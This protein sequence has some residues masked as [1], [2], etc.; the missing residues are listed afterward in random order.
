MLTGTAGVRECSMAA[1]GA[2]V[3]LRCAVF[4]LLALGSLALARPASAIEAVALRTDQDRIDI[5]TPAERFSGRGDRLQ[6]ETA[7]GPD[8]LAGRVEVKAATAG[9]NPNWMVFAL[10]NTTEKAVERWLVAE[11]FTFIGSGLTFPD[12]D[13]SRIVAVTPSQGFVPDRI[14][15]DRADIFQVSIEPGQ[16]VTFA[17]EMASDRFPHVTLWKPFVYEA[18]QRERT[19]LNGILLGISGLLALFLTAL[20]VANHKAVFPATGVLAWSVLAWL[21]VDFGFWHRIFRLTAEDNALYR[22]AA[23]AAVAASLVLFLY[24]FLKLARWHSWIRVFWLAWVLCQW[25][26]VGLAPIDPGLAA[27]LARFSFIVI[28]GLGSLFIVYLM[29]ANQDRAL[30]LLPSWLLLL[31]WV[32]AAALAA[33][34]RLSGEFIAVGLVSG[35]VLI[36]LL[37]G[38][39]VTQVAFRSLEGTP[40]GGAEHNQ[41]RSFA[42]EGAGLATFEWNSRRNDVQT[43]PI[44]EDVLGLQRGRLTCGLDDWL[45]HVGPRDQERLREQF[46]DIAVKGGGALHAEFMMRGSDNAPHWFALRGASL[47]QSDAR[48][49]RCVGIL[50]ETTREKQAQERILVDAI[51]DHRTGLPNREL[52][53]DRLGVAFR[54]ARASQGSLVVVL[55]EIAGLAALFDEFDETSVE[56]GLRSMLKRL[57]N[58]LSPLDTV[59]R[60][61][62]DRYAVLFADAGGASLTAKHI[63]LV[64]QSLRGPVP[65]GR[66]EQVFNVNLGIALLLDEHTEPSAVMR[67]AEAAL[68][69]AKRAGADR[70]EVFRPNMRLEADPAAEDI[71]ALRK[72]VERQQF[73]L[74]FQPVYG[75][76]PERLAGFEALARW[77]HPV[78]GPLGLNAFMPLA[79]SGGFAVPLA[80]HLL[81]MAG[82]AALGWQKAL[83]REQE[84]VFVNIDLGEG[85]P[86]RLDV[87]Q[88]VRKALTRAPL[89]RGLLRLCISDSAPGD[90]PELAMEILDR[91]RSVGAGICLTR[92]GAGEFP[93]SLLPRMALDAVKLD[94]GLCLEGFASDGGVALLRG[95]AALA[96][97]LGLAIHSDALESQ[98]D[99]PVLRGAGCTFGSGPL[100]GEP[101]DDRQVADLL[102]TVRSAERKSER[103]GSLTGGLL[104]KPATATAAAPANDPATSLK[105]TS[106]RKPSSQPVSQPATPR[107]ASAAPA[108]DYS[109]QAASAPESEAA[110][111]DQALS[112]TALASAYAAAENQVEYAMAANGGRGGVTPMG[113]FPQPSHVAATGG[114]NGL[115][116]GLGQGGP[117]PPPG[118]SDTPTKIIRGSG[119]IGAAAPGQSELAGG[120]A[121]LQRGQFGTKST[122]E[123][124]AAAT[125]AP[126]SLAVPVEPPPA[127]K[128]PPSPPFQAPPPA[129]QERPAGGVSVGF[130]DGLPDADILRGLAARLEAALKRD[131]Q[132]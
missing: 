82:R 45:R 73:A 25:G 128:P 81:E 34:G 118:R 55:F 5:T 130:A 12:L 46:K 85:L 22:A 102:A 115:A 96:R 29:L 120:L 112:A 80:M 36:L 35:L 66:T 18:K 57:Q 75:L 41:T 62:S 24:T 92:F 90:N 16:T 37:L 13:A 77:Q 105:R 119:V 129:S 84:P 100:Y 74:V 8:G 2:A 38:F 114:L 7:P 19:L 21:C 28:A 113:A 87:V 23:E 26:L 83:P 88:E 101:L 30:A 6:I 86:L 89:P 39:T 107:A 4:C 109:A 31:V 93:V 131:S 76:S 78:R 9:T 17:A 27:T 95:V 1:Q 3:A 43:G 122:M 106:T 52:F 53:A 123:G 56:G 99:L 117:V 125:L 98:E 69:R 103:R 126:P 94:R 97:E 110:R 51:R 59:G 116:D 72:A 60:M 104:T 58:A 14:A 108:A 48:T 111:Y 132:K 42:I 10:R 32:F 65:I 127:F 124:M 63:E 61:G 64:R 40:A 15:S 44:I 70:Y 47:P 68:D 121:R 11:R 79:A 54:R 67:D 33:V 20:F 49:V 91:L 50:R 71:A